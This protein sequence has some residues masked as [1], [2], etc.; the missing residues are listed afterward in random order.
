MDYVKRVAMQ[1]NMEV[2]EI[3][4][5]EESNSA[6]SHP[7]PP[8]KAAPN[9]TRKQGPLSQ[10]LPPDIIPY[11]ANILVDP[12]LWD[13]NFDVTFLFGTNEFL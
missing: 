3:T 4:Q 8:N 10:P 1:N 12:S 11:K 7:Q 9:N 5:S 6:R 2:D 13:S